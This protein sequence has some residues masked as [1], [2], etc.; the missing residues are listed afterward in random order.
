MFKS[1]WQWLADNKEQLTIIFTIIAAGYVLYEYLGS[2]TDAKVKRAMDF[3]A[4]YGE[5]ELLSARTGLDTLLFDQDFDKILEQGNDAISKAVTDR[6]LDPNVRLLADFYGQVA[7][8]MKNGLCDVQT[9]C[10][11]FRQGTKELR[12]NFYGLFCRWQKVWKTNLIEPTYLYFEKE[13]GKESAGFGTRI[14]DAISQWFIT[15]FQQG[16]A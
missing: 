9:A 12:N 13:C 6:E 4:R 7:T 8:C 10:A 15:I 1:G 2:Q 11:A 14:S 5:K 16:G 3:Q